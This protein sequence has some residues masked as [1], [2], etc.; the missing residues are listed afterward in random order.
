MKISLRNWG[1][2]SRRFAFTLVELLVVIAVIA[3]LAAMLLP[4]LSRAKASALVVACMNN[5]RQMGIALNMYVS[6]NHAYPYLLAFIGSADSDIIFH[7]EDALHIYDP[8]YNPL[9]WT[10]RACQCPAYR[11]AV[12]TE[13]NDSLPGYSGSYAYNGWGTQ[14]PSSLSSLTSLGLG[15]EDYGGPENPA[16]GQQAKVPPVSESQVKAPS[17][18]FAISDA[19]IRITGVVHPN[20]QGED[21]MVCEPINPLSSGIVSYSQTQ[22][23]PQHGQNFNVLFC[24]GHVKAIK[25]NDLFNPTNTAI[26]WN[27]DHQ[28]HPE[29]WVP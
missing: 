16:T 17:E 19:R 25:T 14:T 10:N 20:M 15:D 12:T 13:P 22:A 24:D 23:P 4:A 5:E 8:A 26:Y 1:F 6:D 21:F 27:N 28:P 7:W 2:L 3:I 11:G 18:M 29:T 9:S